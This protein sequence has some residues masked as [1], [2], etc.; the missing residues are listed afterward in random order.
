ML[1]TTK[2]VQLFFLEILLKMAPFTSFVAAC[3]ND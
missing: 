3:S 1:N 2:S